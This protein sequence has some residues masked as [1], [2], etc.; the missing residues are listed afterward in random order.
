M[1]SMI[2]STSLSIKEKISYKWQE[3]DM[4]DEILPVGKRI[5][6]SVPPRFLIHFPAPPPCPGDFLTKTLPVPIQMLSPE[7]T[8]FP[9]GTSGWRTHNMHRTGI[10]Q[11]RFHRQTSLKTIKSQF[12]GEFRQRAEYHYFPRGWSIGDMQKPLYL[13]INISVSDPHPFFADPDPT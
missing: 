7:F 3:L 1:K 6:R 12:Q 9:L 11:M 13:F 10:S 4:S 5:L 8:Y 2:G